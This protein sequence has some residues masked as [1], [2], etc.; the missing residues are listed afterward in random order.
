MNSISNLG[1]AG[2]GAMARRTSVLAAVIA[3][4]LLLLALALSALTAPQTHAHRSILSLDA[5]STVVAPSSKVAVKIQMYAFAPAALTITQGT[6]VTWTNYDTAPHTVTVSSGPVTFS[7]PELQKGQ[8]FTYTFTTP[9]TYSY[10]CAVHPDMTATV[11]VKAKPGGPTTSPTPT[12][13]GSTTSSAGGMGSMGGT[14]TGGTPVAASPSCSGVSAAEQKFLL[15]VY[16]GHLGESPAQ[17]VADITN[18]N[19]YA[20]THTVLISGMLQSL[21]GGLTDAENTFLA[22]VY[23]GHLGESP[24]QQVADILN[25]DQYAK[26]HTVLISK[27]AQS[28]IGSC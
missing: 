20:L 19:Q 12:P 16:A 15:H 28:L 18:V 2:R 3:G 7:S 26:T 6:A 17:Q 4:A 24:A 8:S 27:M 9:G 1:I 23:A 13:T 21:V 11:V 25:V 10:Y 5:G 22:H 14:T